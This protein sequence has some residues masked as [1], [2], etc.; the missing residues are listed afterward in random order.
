MEIWFLTDAGI[1]FTMKV[2]A[3]VSLFEALATAVFLL[4]VV[5]LPKQSGQ[6]SLSGY[7]QPDVSEWT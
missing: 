5:A 7:H 4:N 1:C 2:N 6:S 3:Q